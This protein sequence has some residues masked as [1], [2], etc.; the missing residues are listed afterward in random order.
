MTDARTETRIPLRHPACPV[1]LVGLMGAGK[2]RI[3]HELARRLDLDFVDG[4]AEIEKAAGCTIAEFFAQYGEAAFREGER[5]VYARLLD[6]APKVLATGGGAFMDAETRAL[7]QD[8]AISVWLRADLDVLVRR[9][10]RKN[11]R[12]LLN[13]GDPRR[14]LADLMD[15]RYPVYAQAHLTLDS[16]DRPVDQTLDRLLDALDDHLAA[17]PHLARSLP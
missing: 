3:G 4:D 5:R 9:C 11:T 16:D 13:N 10:G 17:H 15:R 8:Q 14:I 1:V 6:G 12:P 7:I 2:S